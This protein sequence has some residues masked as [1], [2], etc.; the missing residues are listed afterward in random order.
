[1]TA[2]PLRRL[3]WPGEMSPTQQF[4]G[5]RSKL[6]GT[7]SPVDTTK[8]LKINEFSNIGSQVRILPGARK[9]LVNRE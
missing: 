5:Q 6:S 7:Q 4:S 9:V 2:G 3:E 8:T 1:M